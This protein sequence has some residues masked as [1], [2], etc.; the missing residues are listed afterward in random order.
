MKSIIRPLLWITTLYFLPLVRIAAQ[1]AVPLHP[2]VYDT[3][4]S[5]DKP[6]ISAT[7]KLVYFEQN[8]Q[9]GD[10]KLIIHYPSTNAYDTLERAGGA[11]VSPGEDFL[12]CRIRPFLRETRKARLDGKKKDELPK[13]SLLVYALNGKRYIY[14][15]LKSFGIPA[16]SGKTMFA[17]IDKPEPK[18][19]TAV[20]DTLSADTVAVK[21]KV[22]PKKKKDKTETYLLKIIY[23][24]D[25]LI[26]THEQVTQA[27]I[28]ETGASIIYATC[29]PDSIPVSEVMFFDTEKQAE[30]QLFSAPGHIRNLAVDA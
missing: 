20:N 26:F 2:G 10:G 27:V 29:K 11:Q 4:H 17:L 7:G 15:G 8:P 6:G 3:W 16:K 28:S 21:K 1:D 24:A 30:R 14:P 13:D 9:Y 19:D 5:I 12:A 22:S 25:S 23:P 18:E